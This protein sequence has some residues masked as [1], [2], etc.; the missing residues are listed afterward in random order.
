[1]RICSG[2]FLA[3][4]S[5][6]I[7]LGAVSVAAQSN[8]DQLQVAPP[9][10]RRA[11]PPAPNTPVDELEQR[12]DDLR[13]Q[14]A[15]LDALDY[16]EAALKQKSADGLLWNKIGI[17]NLQ[18]QRFKDAR[19][20]FERALKLDRTMADARNNLAVTFY[21][22]RSYGRA[23]KEYKRAIVMRPDVASYYSNMGAAYFSRK[24]FP[25][26]VLA[27]GKALQLDPDVLERT[28]RAGVTAQ[29]P[30]PEDRAHYDY[31]VA[32]LYAKM[33]IA[34]RSLE[35]LRKAMEEGYKGIDGVYKDGEFA[36]LRKDPRF[37]QL[38]AAKPTAIPQ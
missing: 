37:A 13:A 18:L 1:M 2:F 8:F 20:D 22:M 15:Y 28:S 12:G 26:A 34:D 30:S 10:M 31:E 27:Y 7:V 5:T 9:Q 19:K 6:L 24:Q 23:I 16:Y 4:I 11:E 17:T 38:M 29:L 32:K 25:E 35:Y 14:K 36:T 3:V 21:E 33:G